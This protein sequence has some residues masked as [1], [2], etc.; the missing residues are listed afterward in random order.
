MNNLWQAA[1]LLELDDWCQGTL[2]EGPAM[3]DEN[4]RPKRCLVGAM[5]SIPGIAE[6]GEWQALREVIAENYP[7]FRI[8]SI[9]M[10][11]SGGVQYASFNDYPGRTKEE[12][13]AVLQK[14]AA[15]V[16]EQVL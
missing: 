2:Y 13:I 3:D 6:Q 1:E 5:L 10:E 9:S 11:M 7:E 12:V 16:D 4:S 15:K 8:P 14:A